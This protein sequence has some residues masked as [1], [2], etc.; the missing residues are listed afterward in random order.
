MNLTNNM[1]E[2]GQTTF[3]L[4]IMDRRRK[5][6]TNTLR[7]AVNYSIEIQGYSLHG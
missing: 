3:I 4:T 7:F 5:I 6:I 1:Y 2:C